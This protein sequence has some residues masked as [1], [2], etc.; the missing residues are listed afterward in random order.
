ML[1]VNICPVVEVI[2]RVSLSDAIAS[3]R[4]FWAV[5][6]NFIVILRKLDRADLNGN[7]PSQ[8]IS[9]KS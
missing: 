6:G 5:N 8:L 1:V 4:D 9:F 2:V 3:A 7:A